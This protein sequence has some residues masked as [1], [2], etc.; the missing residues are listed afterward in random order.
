[1]ARLA[2]LDSTARSVV[3]VGVVSE[4]VVVVVDGVILVLIRYHLRR[5]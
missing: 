5:L 2:G 4:V 1:M 3:V